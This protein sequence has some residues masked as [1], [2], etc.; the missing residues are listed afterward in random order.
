M[1][2]KRNDIIDLT[3]EKQ[4]QRFQNQFMLTKR[5]TLGRGKVKLGCWD[6]YI[7]TTICKIHR[8]QGTTI[9]YREIIL[10]TV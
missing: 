7:H 4:T 5:E 9:Q 3:K 8:Q 6:W 10:N 1:E 2:S